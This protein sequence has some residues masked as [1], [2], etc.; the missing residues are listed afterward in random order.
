MDC[1]ESCM[2]NNQACQNKECRNWMD[3]AEDLNC[4]AVCARQ[5]GPLSLRDVAKRIGVSYVR[6][7]QIEEA[8]LKK[9][10]RNED[11]E[12]YSEFFDYL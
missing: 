4:A 2:T 11:F 10:K 8:A 7:K 12:E 6:I 1:I 9:I 3:Y 5:N